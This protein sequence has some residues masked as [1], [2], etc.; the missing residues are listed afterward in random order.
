MLYLKNAVMDI[1]NSVGW[2]VYA[3]GTEPN[4]LARYGLT[5]FENGGLLDDKK[6]I[7]NGEQAN[8]ALMRFCDGD[9]DMI[10]EGHLDGADFV[11]WLIDEG[12][13]E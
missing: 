4:S 8:D 13:I 6:F 9:L 7:M 1:Q 5:L 3:D 10:E 11:N 2:A 12:Y